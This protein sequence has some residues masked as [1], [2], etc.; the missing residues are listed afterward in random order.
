MAGFLVPFAT[1]ALIERQ[2]VADA[3]DEKS[4]EIIDT[5]SKKLTTQFDENQKSLAN[6][7]ANYDA[8][9]TAFGMP[10]AEIA[11]RSG[12]LVDVNTAQ[13]VDHVRDNLEKAHPGFIKWIQDKDINTLKETHPDFFENA[14][15]T[16]YER[17]K[18]KLKSNREFTAKNM[19]GGAISSLSKLFLDKDKEEEEPT[20]VEKAQKFLFGEPVTTQK[21]VAFES[22]LM[23]EVGEPVRIESGEGRA[24]LAVFSMVKEFYKSSGKEFKSEAELWLH[25]LTEIMKWNARAGENFF[26]LSDER[27]NEVGSEILPVYGNLQLYNKV[28]DKFFS[29]PYKQQMVADQLAKMP[30]WTYVNQAI[31]L[32]VKM[33]HT[34]DDKKALPDEV[35]NMVGKQW[36]EGLTDYDSLVNLSEAFASQFKSLINTALDVAKDVEGGDPARVAEIVGNLLTK[37]K[38]SDELIVGDINE[39]D[40]S[41][42]RG[43]FVTS[44]G[45]EWYVY[46]AP[47]GLHYAIAK[48]TELRLLKPPIR[49]SLE[50]VEKHLTKI[51]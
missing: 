16:S 1:G 51:Q 34:K 30:A 11:Q 12:M 50:E 2:R 43:D 5:V 46:R 15:S 4:G 48:N 3:Y 20:G 10:T 45:T 7:S 17:A 44:D 41:G 24:D 38:F 47:D 35:L 31:V 26:A 49:L 39:E 33:G 21:G 23:E 25:S 42:I 14:F 27:Q 37:L 6:E 28:Y 18:A 29:S 9:L 22:A 40:Q 8:V 36:R 13:V 32:A 19:N